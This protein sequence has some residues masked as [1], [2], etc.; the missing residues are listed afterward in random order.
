MLGAGRLYAPSLRG[1]RAIMLPAGALVYIAVPPAR[2]FATSGLES[3]LVLAYLGPAVVDD[4]VLVAAAARR[5]QDD[6]RNAVSRFIDAALAF[7]AGVSACWSG[8]SWR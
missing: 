4:G 6:Q 3:G 8:P 2:D 1:R 5:D 7:V